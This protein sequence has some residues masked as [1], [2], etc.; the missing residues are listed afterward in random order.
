M[1]KN[2]SRPSN[3]M[4]KLMR[5]NI[6]YSHEVWVVVQ[7]ITCAGPWSESKIQAASNAQSQSIPTFLKWYTWRLQPGCS[8]YYPHQTVNERREGRV[9]ARFEFRTDK[10]VEELRFDFKALRGGRRLKYARTVDPL[11]MCR[12]VGSDAQV[13][14]AVKDDRSFETS[15]TSEIAVFN[16]GVGVE[17]EVSIGRRQG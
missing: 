11:E 6:A 13:F 8:V 1:E 14:F 5:T 10:E 3:A 12:E 7:G 16:S 9:V 4:H 17:L 15:F 2:A